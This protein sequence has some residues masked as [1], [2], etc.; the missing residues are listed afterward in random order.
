[1][2]IEN[3]IEEQGGLEGMCKMFGWQGGTIHQVRD[4][5]KRRLNAHGVFEHKDT[6]E[7]ITI[8]IK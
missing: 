2:T 5:I 1:M 4:E 3:I 7:L 8:S 6:K